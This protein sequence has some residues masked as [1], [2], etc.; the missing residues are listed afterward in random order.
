MDSIITSTRRCKT[1][2]KDKPEDEFYHRKDR[3]N[4]RCKSCSNKLTARRR[5]GAGHITPNNWTRIKIYWDYKCA[6][7]GADGKEINRNGDEIKLTKDRVIPG[8]RG[9]KYTPAN[10][11]PACGRCNGSKRGKRVDLWMKSQD[12]NY[13]VFETKWKSMD[14][15]L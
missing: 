14:I 13:A 2:K 5:R 3:L 7:C 11:V 10:V 4:Y 15:T 12:F 6:Y 8:R 9:G 1:C